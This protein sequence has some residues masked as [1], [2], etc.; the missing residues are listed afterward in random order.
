MASGQRFRAAEHVGKLSVDGPR[1]DQVAHEHDDALAETDQS[2]PL[3]M[4]TLMLAMTQTGV[5]DVLMLVGDGRR[6]RRR[7]VAVPTSGAAQHGDRKS[8]L[9]Q[10]ASGRR[11]DDVVTSRAARLKHLLTVTAVMWSE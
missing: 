11:R 10:R 8:T 6:R 3:M 9:R 2:L 7:G 5:T 4:L 1:G